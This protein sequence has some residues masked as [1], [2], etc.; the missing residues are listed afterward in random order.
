MPT[1]NYC[2]PQIYSQWFANTSDRHI[3][4]MLTT[5][6]LDLSEKG[7]KRNCKFE[8]RHFSWQVTYYCL[9]VLGSLKICCPD[10]KCLDIYEALNLSVSNCYVLSYWIILGHQFC[11]HHLRFLRVHIDADNYFLEATSKQKLNLKVKTYSWTTVCNW[12]W[13][14]PCSICLLNHLWT[15]VLIEC[16]QSSH[17]ERTDNV[18]FH[19]RQIFELWKQKQVA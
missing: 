3:H 16:L 15:I 12:C 18:H 17:H 5:C 1:F 2:C 9:K 19:C 11:A 10:K 6:V 13:P 7:R 8:T 4:I 14:A